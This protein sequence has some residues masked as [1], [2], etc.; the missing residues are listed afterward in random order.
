MDTDLSAAQCSRIMNLVAFVELLYRA[1][2]SHEKFEQRFYDIHRRRLLTSHVSQ[3]SRRL[4]ANSLIENCVSV[5][6]PLAHT[7]WNS[8]AILHSCDS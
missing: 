6:K 3:R 1:A 7:V 4:N 5:Q 8:I 2:L